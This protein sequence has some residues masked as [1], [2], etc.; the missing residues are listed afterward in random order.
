MLRHQC[1]TA[2][3]EPDG[4]ILQYLCHRDHVHGDST[5]ISI[6]SFPNI[7]KP[8]AS[9]NTM[10]PQRPAY[11][12]GPGL[13]QFSTDTELGAAVSGHCHMYTTLHRAVRVNHITILPSSGA[14][15]AF[16]LAI[17]TVR[18]SNSGATYCTGTFE[19]MTHAVAC[20][21]LHTPLRDAESLFYAVHV[22]R[23][24][25]QGSR[26]PV[27]LYPERH[28]CDARRAKGGC[29]RCAIFNDNILPTLPSKTSCLN[30]L[31]IKWHKMLVASITT[32]H[33]CQSVDDGGN[34]GDDSSTPQGSQWWSLWC[35]G[36][37]DVFAMLDDAS[38]GLNSVTGVPSASLVPLLSALTIINCRCVYIHIFKYSRLHRA[39]PIA[40]DVS[41]SVAATYSP[42]VRSTSLSARHLDH[43]HGDSTPISI[44][45][46]PNINKPPAS[47]NT[48]HPQRPAYSTGP[49]LV[50]FSTDTELCAAVSGHC[51]MYTTL[52]RAVC[53]NHITILP[54]S[55]ALIA[56]DLAICTVRTSNSGATYCTGT[57]K[58]MTHA[59][60]CGKL[61]TPL[62]DAESL[63]YAVHVSR[64]G[65]QGSRHP[66][67]LYPERHTCDARRAKGGCSRCD[68]FNDNILPT[69]PS[70][71]SCL[72]PLVIKW[73][74]MLVASI[75]TVHDWQSVDDGGNAGDDSSTPQG[76]QWWSLWCRGYRDVFAMLDDAST[77]LNIPS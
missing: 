77:G 69:L 44:C 38:T 52:H 12:T 71:T 27:F 7:N 15:I 68:I 33:D 1:L 43:V 73:H 40:P 23:W 11:P 21:K 54:S 47:R 14:L 19:F 18:T 76:S 64:W 56:F 53:V 4:S 67:F 9:R 59:V 65:W 39:S 70:K 25:W 36:Y 17:C 57:F 74:K 50:Q 2:G 61:H 28:T 35:R 3:Q 30:P 22:S 29:S 34:A 26:Y 55:G 31:V 72:N 20:G 46:L 16:D 45:S 13:V 63:F 32:V 60:A 66:V 24:G 48:M 37:R 51:H 10:H 41:A 49:G 42:P 62:R 8:P 6:C 58:F 5:P 75:T